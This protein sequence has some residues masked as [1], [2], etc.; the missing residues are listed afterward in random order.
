M[1]KAADF[2]ETAGFSNLCFE[3][4]MQTHYEVGDLVQLDDYQHRG[5]GI[6]INIIDDHS[7]VQIYWLDLPIEIYP[8]FRIMWLSP[9][10][11]RKLL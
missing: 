7:R 6:I 4:E 8:D 3:K 11:L 5:I 2:K 1:S 9:I 10:S